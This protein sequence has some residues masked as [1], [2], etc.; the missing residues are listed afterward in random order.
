MLNFPLL[1]KH[2]QN[3]LN[4]MGLYKCP[5]CNQSF[6]SH[7]GRKAHIRALHPVP[8][9]RQEPRVINPQATQ[10]L[11]STTQHSLQHCTLAALDP[12]V[13]RKPDL[14]VFCNEASYALAEHVAR[15][16]PDVAEFWFALVEAELVNPE[17][18]VSE[19]VAVY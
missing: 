19:E 1:N 12:P 15:E 7:M 2:V 8:A 5:H 3:L 9:D 13:E 14:C 10:T 11:Q 17:R 4:Q 16:H 18:G 6:L